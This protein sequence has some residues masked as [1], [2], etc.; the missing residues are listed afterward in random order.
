M[1]L[2][3]TN[4]STISM[5]VNVRASIENAF[6]TIK[7]LINDNKNTEIILIRKVKQKLGFIDNAINVFRKDEWKNLNDSDK[8]AL[9]LLQSQVM[10]FIIS[11]DQ[12]NKKERLKETEYL[13]KTAKLTLTTA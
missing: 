8:L 10:N 2:N 13:L 6:E 1:V 7:Q 9:D 4:R 12:K 11:V 3:T 5:A